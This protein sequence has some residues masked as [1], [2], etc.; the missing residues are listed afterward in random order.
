MKRERELA[1]RIQSLESLREAVGAMKDLSAHHFRQIRAAIEPARSYREGVERVLGRLSL[2]IPAGHGPAGLVLI[3]GDLGLS[4]AYNGGLARAAAARRRELGDGPTFCVG[5]RAATML[6][7]LGLRPERTWSSPASAQGI[8]RLLLDVAEDLLGDYLD[9]DM[10]CLE[11]VSARFEGVGRYRP[12]TTRL[13]PTG[14]SGP[15]ASVPSPYVSASRVEGVAVREHLY[16]TFYDLFLDA[17]AS[18]HGARLAATEAAGKWL[19]RNIERMRRHWISA[20]R[21]ASTQ[22]VIEIAAGARARRLETERVGPI[23]RSL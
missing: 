10:S 13:L 17:L 15:E 20:R 21:E 19:D 4:G 8:T 11:L 16:I 12:V 1:R 3:G 9:R 22:E 6:G 18:E 7:R 5:S 23:E 14:A 2:G